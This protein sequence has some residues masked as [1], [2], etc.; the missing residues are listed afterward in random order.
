MVMALLPHAALLRPFLAVARAGTLSAAARELGVSQP[1]LTKAVH[2]L[3]QQVG[4][5]LFDRRARGMALTASGSA[6]LLHARLIEAQCRVADAEIA[7]LAHGEGGRL[8]IG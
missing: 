2:K 8:A 7:A 5:P 4:V 3:E 1:A 6:L